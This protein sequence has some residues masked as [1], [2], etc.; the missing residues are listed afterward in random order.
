MTG[1]APKRVLIAGAAGFIGSHLARHIA[2]AGHGV[3]ALVRPGSSLD[4]LADLDGRLSVIRADLGNLGPVAAHIAELQPEVCLDAA[5]RRG[6]ADSTGH[7][8]ALHHALSLAELMAAVGCHRYLHAGTCFE[9]A[10]TDRLITE[11]SP[12]GPHTLYG[13]CKQ[14]ASVTVQMLG[15][16]AETMSVAW[17]RIFYVYGP[18]E[19]PHRLVPDVTGRLL[20]GEPAPTTAGE[21][22]RDYMHVEDVAAA[23]WTVATSGY[24]GPVNIAT[25]DQV[26][27]RRVVEAIGALVGRPDLLEIGA[28]SYRPEEP[29]AIRADVSLLRRLGWQPRYTLESGLKQTVEWWRRRLLEPA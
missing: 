27:V 26:P 25:G 2:A 29:P 15:R 17:P 22:I 11:S 19:A 8:T 7:L 18:D 28:K 21:Q 9:Y 6:A 1:A 16:V 4:R 10:T 5:W 3:L 23:I 14:A 24:E 12:V 20:H 13:A